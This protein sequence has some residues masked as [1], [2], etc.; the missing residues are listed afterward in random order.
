MKASLR[1]ELERRA[2]GEWELYS[3]RA[4]SR[5]L[6]VTSDGGARWH[7]AYTGARGF[8]L[9]PVRGSDV[10]YAFSGNAMLVSGLL[11]GYG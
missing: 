9:F 11:L 7:L 8:E 1:A 3:K 5:E 6:L 2:P 10:V 4:E